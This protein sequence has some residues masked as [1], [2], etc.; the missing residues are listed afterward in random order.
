MG[1]KSTNTSK[2]IRLKTYPTNKTTTNDNHT[3]NKQPTAHK[4]TKSNPK[5]IQPTDQQPNSLKNH[6]TILT[7]IQQKKP[8]VHQNINQITNQQTNQHTKSSKSKTTKNAQIKNN[9]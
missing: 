4:N 6:S 1:D 7:P 2:K 9:H 5:T 3:K 8:K